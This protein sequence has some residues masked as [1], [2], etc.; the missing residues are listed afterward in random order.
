MVLRFEGTRS[1][2]VGA[3][4]CGSC[5]VCSLSLDVD[6]GVPEL[7]RGSRVECLSGAAIVP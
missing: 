2:G 4:L 5:G 3:G 1:P 6:W 7:V